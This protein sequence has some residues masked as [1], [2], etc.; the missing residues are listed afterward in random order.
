M[1]LPR[2]GYYRI[3]LLER[4]HGFPAALATVLVA[5]AGLLVW[6]GYGFY[7]LGL[8]AR[9]DHPDFQ[10]LR[11]SG[12]LGNGLGY[13]GALLVTLNLLYLARR[14][15]LF[16]AGSMR[17]WLNIHV[18]TGLLG[19][20]LAA[21]HS[22][23]QFRSPLAK[24]TAASLGVVVVTGII[25]R[26]IHALAGRAGER[27]MTPV[28]QALEER[29]PGLGKVLLAAVDAFPPTELPANASHL[30]CLATM[31]RWWREARDRR[32]AVRI[33]G[34][35]HKAVVGSRELGALVGQA[36]QAAAAEVRA[37]SR[38]A[39]LRSWRSLHRLSAILMLLAVAVHAAV[40]W[41]YGYRWVFG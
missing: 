18:F 29:A 14:R 20:E 35:G 4:R 12:L 36:A 1:E 26:F 11:P 39:L 17:L 27:H 9:V 8:E 30:R 24:L 23:F 7:T 19:A 2:S 38:T 33:V 34:R 40:A 28:I 5:V 3:R 10:L 21:F 6:R 22:A 41:H 13:A 37:V 25:G 31:P 15:N 32:D 16:G